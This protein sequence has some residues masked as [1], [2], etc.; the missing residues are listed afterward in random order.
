MKLLVLFTCAALAILTAAPAQADEAADKLVAEVM[1]AHGAAA[2][3]GVKTLRFT[4]VVE[5]KGKAEPL[6]E[7]KHVWEIAAQRATVSWKGK[8]VTI[9]LADPASYA[10]GDAKAAYGRWVNDSYW[11]IAP[12]KLRDAGTQVRA[13]GKRTVDGAEYETLE[14]SY[15]GVGLTPGDRYT[16]YLDPKTKLLVRWDYRPTADK[17]FSSPRT[18]FIE[19]AGMKFSTVHPFTDKVLRFT[20]VSADR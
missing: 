18:D 19:V 4:F 9:N 11:L 6:L 8:T 7:A 15:A 5:E 12:F 13:G 3:A 20:G 17:V 10:E 1:R 2:F 14:I 16:W